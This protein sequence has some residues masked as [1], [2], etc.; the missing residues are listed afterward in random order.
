[1]HFK[2]SAREKSILEN[3]CMGLH[4]V[5]KNPFLV[6]K[7][8]YHLMAAHLSLIVFFFNYFVYTCVFLYEQV[9]A[10]TYVWTSDI[11]ACGSSPSIMSDVG[12]GEIKLRFGSKHL[13]PNELP[14]QMPLPVI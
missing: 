2:S 5:D 3:K 10:T 14:C 12:R 9:Q 4:P 1:M 7:V 8:K 13:L 11:N 6:L